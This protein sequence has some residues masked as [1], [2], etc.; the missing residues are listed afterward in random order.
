MDA[1]KH[2]FFDMDGTLTPSREPMSPEMTTAVIQL[3]NSGRTVTVISGASR[4]QM[5][6]QLRMQTG[7]FTVLA[8]NGNDAQ[9]WLGNQ[10]WLNEIS[11]DLKYWVYRW[12]HDS[13]YY[14]C[15]MREWVTWPISNMADMVEDRGCQISYSVLGHHAAL[16]KK[17]AFDPTGAKRKEMLED[18]PWTET[19]IE[20][21]IGGTTCFDFFLA[22]QNKG[23]NIER[24]IKERHWSKE[25]SLY[26][27]DALFPGGNDEAVVGVIDTRA[28]DSVTET[29]EL[30]RS[31]L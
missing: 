2:V 10:L 14:V 29:L 31:M 22:G 28:V 8:Q 26:I 21:R 3:L 15:E 23:T 13:L 7:N 18:R 12:I 9:D 6:K 24:F 19:Q 16:E 11:W 27:G 30:I 1:K 25:E 20:V 5:Q 4:E 17:R